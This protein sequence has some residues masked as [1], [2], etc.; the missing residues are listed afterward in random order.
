M[1]KR[2]RS[3]LLEHLHS[4]EFRDPTPSRLVMPGDNDRLHYGRNV[5]PGG[6]RDVAR[7]I[8]EIAGRRPV[9]FPDANVAIKGEA[10]PVWTAFRLAALRTRQPVAI[11]TGAVLDE[12]KEW[13]LDP[14]HHAD[15]AEAI[16]S[17]LREENGWVV[18]TD[19]YPGQHSPLFESVI[20]YTH[21]LGLRRQL[22]IPRGDKTVLGTPAGSKNDMMNL[23]KDH[24]GLRAVPLA[25]KGRDELEQ[26]GEISLRDE[27][28]CLLA[29]VY[30]LL[31]GRETFILTADYDLTEI[32]CKVQWFFDTHYKAWLAANLV[33]AGRFGEPVRVWEDSQ[34]QFF[35]G[36]VSLYSKRPH[37]LLEVLPASHTTVPVH[38]MYVTPMGQI[39]WFTFLFEREMVGMLTTRG[40]TVGRCTDLFGD[41]NIHVDLGPLSNELGG[42][43]IGVGQ[44]LEHRMDIR[45][46]IIGFSHLDVTHT[47][48]CQE[49]FYPA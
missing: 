29:V 32:F 35:K 16:R 39:Q 23:V 41:A 3:S 19:L 37:D 11:F 48:N 30:A 43:Y 28:H 45:G 18:W 47:V 36:S 13:L 25:K 5:L 10:E 20:S 14:R 8:G 31:H 49:R 27:A 42:A 34:G 46:T 22:A 21:L 12:L 26:R 38:L 9:W 2:K 4:E 44:D 1:A 33:K 40:G 17:S 15:R 7:F 24:F 6:W